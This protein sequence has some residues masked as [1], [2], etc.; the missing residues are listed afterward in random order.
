M[1]VLTSEVDPKQDIETITGTLWMLRLGGGTFRV[2][3]LL[4]SPFGIQ[5]CTGVVAGFDES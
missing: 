3:Q 1:R 4:H 5:S 2:L